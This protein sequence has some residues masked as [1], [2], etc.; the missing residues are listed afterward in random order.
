[1][2]TFSGLIRLAKAL[3]RRD[4]RA[5]IRTALHAWEVSPPYRC[6]CCDYYGKFGFFGEDCRPGARCPRC[7]SLERHR[8]FALAV[9]RGVIDFTGK[10]VLHF[11]ADGCVASQVTKFSGAVH[12]T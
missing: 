4:S 1:M 5:A 7:G 2:P 8:M 9:S 10:R 3:L 11:A 12:E 6:A